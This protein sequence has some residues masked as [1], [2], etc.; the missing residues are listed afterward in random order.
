MFKNKETKTEQV[1]KYK[2]I[3]T[4]LYDYLLKEKE[5]KK[6]LIKEV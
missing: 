4:F 1:S 5:K 3:H 2:H 6:L